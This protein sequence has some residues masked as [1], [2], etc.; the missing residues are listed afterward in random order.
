MVAP[1]DPTLDRQL[2]AL[3]GARL[4]QCGPW[5][6]E[7]HRYVQRAARG[8]GLTPHDYLAQV[9]D[10]PACLSE[11]TA[12]ATVGHTSFFRHAEHFRHLTEFARRAARH[13]RVL[14]VWSLG[15]STGEEAWSI[16]LTLWRAGLP[17]ELLG[18]DVNARAIERARSRSYHAHGTSGLAR[19][20]E[21]EHWSAPDELARSVRFEVLALHEPLPSAAPERFDLLFCRNVLIYLAPEAVAQ[22]WSMFVRVL[23]PW[24]AVVVSP[25]ESL[26]HI[27]ST[28]TR[29]G[30]LGWFSPVQ[31]A[32]QG[33]NVI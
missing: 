19:V 33:A 4:G 12:A 14:R 9:A 26:N 29:T 32:A 10:R 7:L 13:T 6:V 31:G 24:G 8:Q 17:F 22:A 25:V 28:L 18:T 23:E 15:C 2:T 1:H 30:P 11:L 21:G 27:P 20:S 16:A 5:P 3:L